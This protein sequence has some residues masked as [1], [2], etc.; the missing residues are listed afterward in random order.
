M[1]H[2]F[3]GNCENPQS[4]TKPTGPD[5]KGAHFVPC[6]HCWS[7]MGRKAYQKAGIFSA[8]VLKPYS[9][10]WAEPG[11]VHFYTLTDPDSCIP[12]TVPQAHDLSKSW[13]GTG[14]YAGPFPKAWVRERFR[15]GFVFKVENVAYL[16]R[17]GSAMPR[18]LTAEECAEGHRASLTHF[19]NWSDS[20]VAD[21]IH[22]TYEPMS[23]L[24]VKVV[25]DFIKR[26]RRWF[27]KHYP[28]LPP[29]RVAYTG[30]YGDQTQRAHYHLILF[31]WPPHK[32]AADFLE[33]AWKRH[34]D[35]AIVHP[36]R[37]DAWIGRKSWIDPEAA[38]ASY[39]PKDLTKGRR[40]L[41]ATPALAARADAFVRASK[42]PPLGQVALELWRDDVIAPEIDKAGADEVDQ[43]Y[44]VRQMYARHSL[45]F[46][47]GKIQLYPTTDYWRGSVQRLW[48]PQVWEETTHRINTEHAAWATA[49][50]W[51]ATLQE[52]FNEH[53]SDV[54]EANRRNEK[55][56]LDRKARKAALR[57]SADGI[58]SL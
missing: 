4:I 5:E 2:P 33:A 12:M 28:D 47:S 27:T 30:E 31:G 52:E 54:A 58:R 39:I 56:T 41:R 34:H 42:H 50:Q 16:H 9:P 23:T 25:Q 17:G 49:L 45:T 3:L 26:L 48:S 20:D 10:L 53:I 51:D 44:R 21:W 11:W 19:Y 13:D 35:G 8:E 15:H 46:P 36:N 57:L 55:R 14:D 40:E 43:C 37:H 38:A 29:F 6:G 22:G 7:C 32:A 1:S 24:R 18:R